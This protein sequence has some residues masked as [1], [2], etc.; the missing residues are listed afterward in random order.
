MRKFFLLSA[1]VVLLAGVV[2]YLLLSGFLGQSSQNAQLTVTPD[3]ESVDALKAT[4]FSTKLLVQARAAAAPAPELVASFAA[5]RELMARLV[6]ERP[7][8]AL[9]A[10]LTP[11]EV[12]SLPVELRG[13]VEKVVYGSGFYG[14]LATC[15]HSP[16]KEHTTDCKIEHHVIIDDREIPVS[17]Y[18]SRL[19][20]LTEEHASLYGIE[21]DG[22]LALH[23]DD[24]VVFPAERMTDD[25]ARA[26]QLAVIY[27][28]ETTFFEDQN[29]LDEFLKRIGR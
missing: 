11:H 20:R 5:R 23:E 22:I 24:A 25:P 19:D 21:I 26:G 4:D 2:L 17:I 18:G 29:A 6:R 16:L 15:N 3:T 8:E 7:E 14:V 12:E 27:F 9:A 1:L 13:L 10:A 28:G